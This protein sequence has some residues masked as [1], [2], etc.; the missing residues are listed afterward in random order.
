MWLLLGIYPLCDLLYVFT[1]DIG[2][3][4]LTFQLESQLGHSWRSFYCI[5]LVIFCWLFLICVPQE[6]WP[7]L[8][9]FFFFCFLFLL[10][11]WY[12]LCR[13]LGVLILFLFSFNNLKMIWKIKSLLELCCESIWPWNFLAE[14]FHYYFNL[15]IFM[16][17][18]KC[19]ISSWF[20]VGNLA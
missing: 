7:M 12:W 17:L 15:L 20:N 6:Y 2:G 14:N 8:L 5:L 3:T 4:I 9:L 16:V 19:F 1:W 10:V 13:S 18:F 11:E